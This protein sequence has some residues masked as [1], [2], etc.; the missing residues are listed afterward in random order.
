MSLKLAVCVC[1]SAG[2]ERKGLRF[3]PCATHWINARQSFAEWHMTKQLNVQKM[4]EWAGMVF[5]GRPHSVR[6][7]F[8]EF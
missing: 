6:E 4:L 8:F 7:R 1:E 5:E 3:P 2:A